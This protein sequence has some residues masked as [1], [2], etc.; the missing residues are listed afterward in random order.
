MKILEAKN[1]TKFFSKSKEKINIL[2]NI[3]I[4]INQGEILILCGPSGS[5]KSTLLNILGTL[6]NNYSGDLY[7]ENQLVD[8]NYDTTLLRG[9]KMGFV[10]QFHHLLPEF[11]V[12]ENLFLPINI[13]G[14]NNI[15]IIDEMLNYVGLKNRKYHY[16]SELS[17]G[18]RQRVALLRSLV[19][20]PAIV[21]ADEPTGN[22]DAENSR[23]LL[24]LI[25]NLHNKFNQTFI[26]A[27]HDPL[28]L[29]IA[30]RKLYLKNGTINKGS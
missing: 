22:L 5:G 7:I 11:T 3:N 30:T 23:L 13:S 8:N 24:K 14:N 29:E 2:N 25:V 26:I 15:N 27:T 17:G 9:Q 12:Y 20:N 19:N 1:I 10:F 6:D 4:S 28:V 16:P 21:L 18:E